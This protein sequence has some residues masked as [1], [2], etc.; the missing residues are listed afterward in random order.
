MHGNKRHEGQK[1]NRKGY[2]LRDI[3]VNIIL[4]GLNSKGNINLKNF[5][6]AY[7]KFF[8]LFLNESTEGFVMHSTGITF[9]SQTVQTK[10]KE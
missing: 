10:N 2:C 8:M 3:V 5:W 6:F 7:F 9:Y 1:G 4:L